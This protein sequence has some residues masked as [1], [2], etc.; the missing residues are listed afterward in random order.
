MQVQEYRALHLNAIRESLDSLGLDQVNSGG[1]NPLTKCETRLMNQIVMGKMGKIGGGG[2]VWGRVVCSL[3][4][5]SCFLFFFVVV[6]VVVVVFFARCCAG[7]LKNIVGSTISD[8]DNHFELDD[9]GTL[10]A[11]E[12]GC[13]QA[14]TKTYLW[15]CKIQHLQQGETNNGGGNGG[16]KDNKEGLSPLHSFVWGMRRLLQANASAHVLEIRP[17]TPR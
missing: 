5:C 13:I 6:V 2:W 9:D 10:C 15:L 17:E 16:N 12:I 8:Y 1:K 11:E 14:A 7:T 3:L 4:L